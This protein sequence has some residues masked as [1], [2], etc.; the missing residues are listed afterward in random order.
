MSESKRLHNVAESAGLLDIGRST[1]YELI[2]TGEIRTIT[3]G[4][5]RLVPDDELDRFVG[6]T[7]ADQNPDAS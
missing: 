7:F 1:M 3:V 6:R 5:R 2:K 4:R